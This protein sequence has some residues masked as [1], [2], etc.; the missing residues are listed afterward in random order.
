VRAQL[1]WQLLRQAVL[2]APC[3]Q[4]PLLAYTSKHTKGLGRC[5]EQA[6]QC[7]MALWLLQTT[8]WSTG[9][10]APLSAH[11]M[12]SAAWQFADPLTVSSPGR[13]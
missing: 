2:I 10:I 6:G 4:Q 12:A 11:G 5:R 7:C 1:C 3:R 9:Y 13:Q 8:P